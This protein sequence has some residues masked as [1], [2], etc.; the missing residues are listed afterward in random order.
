MIT[1]ATHLVSLP[2]HEISRKP[3]CRFGNYCASLN[4]SQDKGRVNVNSGILSADGLPSGRRTPPLISRIK[5]SSISSLCSS[6]R[7]F[8]IFSNLCISTYWSYRI[9]CVRSRLVRL[10]RLPSCSLASNDT[11]SSMLF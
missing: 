8:Y 10:R 9:R 3:C 5:S 4:Q 7:C 11:A 1:L 2:I 6:Y